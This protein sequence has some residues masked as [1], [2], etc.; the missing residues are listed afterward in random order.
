MKTISLQDLPS[1]ALLNIINSLDYHSVLALRGASK[2]Y[3]NNDYL[4]IELKK[5]Y[6][7]MTRKQELECLF[8][9]DILR[10]YA[11]T[12]DYSA[13]NPTEGETL[14]VLEFPLVDFS[15]TSL[16]LLSLALDGGRQ[17]SLIFGQQYAIPSF[18]DEYH[19]EAG[20]H[21]NKT[22]SLCKAVCINT[23]KDN[24]KAI[25]FSTL[26]YDLVYISF[27]SG[28]NK[29]EHS[30]VKNTLERPEWNTTLQ[31]QSISVPTRLLDSSL[32]ELG[33]LGS[34]PNREWQ[35][36]R[37]LLCHTSMD[38]LR[39]FYFNLLKPCSNY[40]WREIQL[41]ETVTVTFS[42]EEK[43]RAIIKTLS[44]Q[45]ASVINNPVVEQRYFYLQ[46]IIVLFNAISFEKEQQHQS[47]KVQLALSLLRLEDLINSSENVN[48]KSF[49]RIIEAMVDEI[50]VLQSL[51]FKENEFSSTMIMQA[52]QQFIKESSG[53]TP[54]R[55]TMRSSGMQ[56]IWSCFVNCLAF[57]NKKNTSINLWV[58]DK[59][60]FQIFTVLEKLLHTRF[61]MGSV[62]VTIDIKNYFAN[63]PLVF[64]PYAMYDLFIGGL[65][66]NVMLEYSHHQSHYEEVFNFIFNQMRLRQENNIKNRPLLV[67]M[68][69][70]MCDFD[71][72]S[73][74]S[75]IHHFESEIALGN[76]AFFAS[77]SGNKYLQLGTDKELAAL[78]YCHFNP[79]VL[80]EL[81]MIF[82]KDAQNNV[83]GDLDPNSATV[84]LTKAF[85]ERAHELILRFTPLIR[86]RTAVLFDRVVPRELLDKNNYFFTEAPSCNYSS[87]LMAIKSNKT[88]FYGEDINPDIINNVGVLIRFTGIDLRDGIAYSQSNYTLIAG[89]EISI[90]IR[91]SFGTE[92]LAV[93][94][95]SLYFICQSLLL[96]NGY[97]NQYRR[98]NQAILPD[99]IKMIT[100][101]KDALNDLLASGQGLAKKQEYKTSHLLT[102][103]I[104]SSKNNVVKQR[105]SDMTCSLINN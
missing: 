41:P 97:M 27:L 40:P 81:D 91:I 72:K 104:F 16:R 54:T 52:V 65:E 31:Y 61:K 47:N 69:N 33:M 38:S 17:N 57:Y 49:L 10:F 89:P 70:T 92:S 83:V 34:L 82:Q 103:S 63:K 2:F 14:K 37:M 62:S 84:V 44:E 35:L 48:Y 76:L 98:N 66:S 7:K 94:A 19:R 20:T 30:L 58:S 60:F 95:K 78:L 32:H 77:Q 64:T 51:I 85:L 43:K 23:L 79:L 39:A 13:Y 59:S 73:F 46:L 80:P 11:L 45:Q 8:K 5:E 18:L 25:A 67:I 15:N 102:H 55:A 21:A 105:E 36:R 96:I 101:I 6:E 3:Y 24:F 75:L 42:L 9:T 87:G 22:F 4:L 26:V 100:E 50:L 68:D 86:N 88:H 12:S 53:L 74:A 28:S 90:C 29:N 1:I 71:L 99:S 93:I 56:A